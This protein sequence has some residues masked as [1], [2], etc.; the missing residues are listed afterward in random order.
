MKKKVLSETS[1][2]S[3]EIPDISNIDNFKIK[4]FILT[5]LL[6]NIEKNKLNEN[7]YN[8]IEINTYRD[9]NWVM[10]YVRDHVKSKYNFT[11]I[12]IKT[13]VQVHTKHET[14]VKRNHINYLDIHNSPDYTIMYVVEGNNSEITLE[15]NNHR[16]KE[17]SYNIKLKNKSIV[18]WNSD[19]NYY[20]TP[21]L[22]ED[23]RILLLFNCH[24]L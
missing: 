22:E 20:L 9:I 2:Y 8:D 24:I 18:M 5:N 13:F 6:N 15:Y 21:N 16:I 1:I 17:N 11:L 19:L 4:S 3:D 12:P 7:K 23:Y 10:D 14:S